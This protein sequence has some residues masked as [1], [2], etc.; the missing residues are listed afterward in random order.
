MY[1]LQYYGLVVCLSLGTTNCKFSWPQPSFSNC[2]YRHHVSLKDDCCV[3]LQPVSLAC[4]TGP[5]MLSSICAVSS[6]SVVEHSLTVILIACRKL[7][8]ID[9]RLYNIIINERLVIC[10]E[11]LRIFL[12][13]FNFAD[14]FLQFYSIK[15]CQVGPRCSNYYII[16]SHHA[17][18]G[19]LVHWKP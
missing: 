8:I 16:R 17:K 13:G 18:L 3:G 19:S 14:G 7:P 12:K 15:E 6:I 10:S 11:T 1:I 5:V 9:R 4:S 2:L